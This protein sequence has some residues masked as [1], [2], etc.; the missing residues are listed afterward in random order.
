MPRP[1]RSADTAVLCGAPATRQALQDL[2]RHWGR[3]AK[4]DTV[5]GLTLVSPS[6]RAGEAANAENKCVFHAL[7]LFRRVCGGWMKPPSQVGIPSGLPRP[8]GPD[9]LQALGAAGAEVPDSR[10]CQGPR[11]LGTHV[12]PASAAQAPPPVPL[13]PE[14]ALGES[15]GGNVSFPWGPAAEFVRP[16]AK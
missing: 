2:P 5:S 16:D 15:T 8:R 3:R 13:P 1:H 12:P 11:S 6:P 4:P 10:R 9:V 14:P 7:G